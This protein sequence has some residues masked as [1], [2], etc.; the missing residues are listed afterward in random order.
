MRA[1]PTGT[2]ERLALALLI[3][4]PFL[5]YPADVHGHSIFLGLPFALAI[6][7]ALLW[8]SRRWLLGSAR[9]P[10]LIVFGFLLALATL[11][12]L[13][14]TDVATAL[15]RDLYLFTFGAFAL[16]IGASLAQRRLTSEQLAWAVVAGGVL[17]AAA[18]LLQFGAQY[19]FGK[20]ETFD[21]LRDVQSAF[22]GK[23]AAQISTTNWIIEGNGTL[24]GI[25]PFM[26]P[27][28]AGQ[29]MMLSLLP[30][31]WLWSRRRGPAPEWL[32]PAALA[33]IVAALVTTYSRQSWIGALT[34]LGVIVLMR[35]DWRLA[36]PIA[37][38][39]IAF[40]L[41]LP[42]SGHG[43]SAGYGVSAG[44]TS[45]E[46]SATRLELWRQAF[47]LIPHHALIGVG[48]GLYGTLNPDPANQI[49]YAHNFLLDGAVE[50]GIGGALALVAL[51]GLAIV[52]GWRRSAALAVAM[53]TAYFVANMF[54]DVFY[55]PRNGLLLA[56]AFALIG[57]AAV[58]DA[59]PEPSA[60]RTR[61][62][63]RGPSGAP[64]AA[65]APS[66]AGE[67]RPAAPGTPP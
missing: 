59:P 57:G 3:V 2:S 27:P 19:A 26:S 54:D 41:P 12:A 44:N 42:A 32:A 14:S 24:R 66:G 17:G 60:E 30:A 10:L 50:L 13:L 58:S 16:G 23:R 48:P 4:L 62:D 38:I 9:T 65:A 15:S 47:D 29:Y 21:W 22:A 37:A 7:A 49:Y 36:I 39:L 67:R 34:G 52:A 8:Q 25:F 18:I 1:L 61:S 46:S 6:A 64:S 5:F 35:R 43:S 55:F 20:N 40:V 51:F 28:S 33:L 31:A 63:A 11:A 53:L 45:T 56:V